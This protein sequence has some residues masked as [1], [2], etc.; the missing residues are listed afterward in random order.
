MMLGLCTGPLYAD[1]DVTSLTMNTLLHFGAGIS[2]MFESMPNQTEKVNL[3]NTENQVSLLRVSFKSVAQT[4]DDM[5]GKGT[6]EESKKDAEVLGPAL[7]YPNPFRQV[8]GTELGYRLSKNM[9]VEVRIYD[10]LSN[11]IF[12]NTFQAGA[13]GGRIGYNKLSMNLET[14]DGFVLS[15]GVYFY[16]LVNNGKVLAKGKMAVL[17]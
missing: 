11:M 17:P 16:L 6:S 8:E 14:L 3:N 10:M 15:A 5:D 2:R 4:M 12:K 1:F 7:C 13:Q 9:D